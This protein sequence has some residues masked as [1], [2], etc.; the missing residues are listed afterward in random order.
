MPRQASI[1]YYGAYHHIMSRGFKRELLFDDKEDYIYYLECLDEFIDYG[2]KILEYSLM[3]NHIHLL[4]KTK[5]IRLQKIL[6]SINTRYAMYKVRKRGLPGPIFQGRPKSILITGKAHLQV[7]ARYIIRNPLKAGITK[8]LGEYRWSSY[9]YLNKIK[10]PDW[11]DNGEI[12]KEFSKNR[13][14]AIRMYKKYIRKPLKTDD[15]EYPLEIYS[16]IA[17]GSKVIYEKIIKMIGKE[18]RDYARKQLKESDSQKIIRNILKKNKMKL[19]DIIGNKKNSSI[20]IRSQIAYIMKEIF[21]KE[22]YEVKEYLE[23]SD[24]ALSRYIKR[25]ATQI[26]DGDIKHKD[27]LNV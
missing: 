25:V 1:D 20:E 16:G 19:S 7:V 22:R 2:Y 21:H 4:L 27:L 23:I 15:K 26:R 12:L 5:D 17:A 11:Y 9:K 24:S 18:K 14:E 8:R 10:I 6:K 13:Y 3:P